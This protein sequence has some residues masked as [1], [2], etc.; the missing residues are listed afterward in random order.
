[1]RS[2]DPV[3][4]GGLEAGAWVAYYR[5]EW[6][7]FLRCAVGMVRTGFGMSWPR[8]LLGAWFVLRANQKWAPYPDNDPDAAQR[9]MR[10]FYQQVASATKEE[11]D[12]DEAARLEI[13]WWR[14]HRE[15]Q[16]ERSGLGNEALVEA[17]A[18]LY[19]HVYGVPV[20]EVRYAGQMR[21]EATR[22]SDAW[23]EGECDPTSCLIEAER[24]ALVR[25][26]AALLAAVH[27]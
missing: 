11:F 27:R 3:R 1:V 7:R 15:L 26:Y 24:V 17:L 12:I 6:W 23:V 25:S 20:E 5:H 18:V 21:A 14:V 16:R 4:L 2:F 19:A 13:E 10:R 22:L 8:T 9:L